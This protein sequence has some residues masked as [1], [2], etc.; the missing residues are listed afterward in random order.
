MNKT[1]FLILVFL[2]CYLSVYSVNDKYKVIK[3]NGT[4][5]N[6]TKH[7]NITT[8]DELS[9][10]EE[11][12]FKTQNSRFAVINS[13]KGKFIIS[14]SNYQKNQPKTNWIPAMTNISSRSGNILNVI[15]LKKHFSG[16]YLLI[17][18]TKVKV[19]KNSF[20]L[21]KG[22]LFFI[23][24]VYNGEEIYKKIDYQS[25]TLILNKAELLTIDENRIDTPDSLVVE[26][27]YM[28]GENN[29]TF[30]NSFTFVF[31]DEAALKSEVNVILSELK[32]KSYNE[33]LDAINGFLNEFYGK[34]EQESLKNWLS[35]F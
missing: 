27:Y 29:Y 35:N 10:N 18:E 28:K 21:D 26:L 23:K 17:S 34:I 31:P 25:D 19:S 12:N 1:I 16:D 22:N 11:L 30:I 14:S 24:Y 3:V 5:I 33:Q 2:S 15:D 6:V 13:N 20:P 4:V 32:D 7:K 9:L 8:G